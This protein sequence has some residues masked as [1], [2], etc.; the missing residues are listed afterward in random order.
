VAAELGDRSLVDSLLP[1]TYRGHLRPPF[2]VLAETPRSDAVNF[3]TG[4]GGFLQQLIFGYTGLR[5]SEEGLTRRFAPVLPSRVSRLTLRN[6]HLRGR[7]FDV[8]V[9]GDSLR[10][11]S[12]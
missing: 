11:E 10:M 12:R 9:E 7:R 1:L 2:D 3:V 5:L 4:A 8:V 6:F